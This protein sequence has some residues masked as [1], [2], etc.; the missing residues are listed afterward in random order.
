MAKRNYTSSSDART[1]AAPMTAT[2]ASG[3]PNPY[4]TITLNTVTT[5]SLPSDYP[6]TLVVEP[7]ISG[8]EEIITV[9]SQ[10]ST[11]VY[12]VNR[13]SDGTSAKAH[14][15]G[16]VVKHMVTARDL[17]EPQNHAEATG[18]YS[19][20]NDG[21][22]VGV[23]TTYI[24]KSLHGIGASEGNVVGTDKAQTLTNKTLTNP[25]INSASLFGTIT[26]TGTLAFGTNASV[27][28]A[29]STTI[30]ATEIAYLD[31]VTSAI[32]TQ[33][34][35]KAPT[36]SPTF[37]G[38]VTL[39]S[40][41]SLTS[42]TT[43][44][45]TLGGTTTL[46]S[47]GTIALGT[48]ASA[49][50]AN[51]VTISAAEFGYLDGLTSN[52]QTQITSKLTNPGAWTSWTPTLSWTFAGVTNSSKYI[53]IG[54][55]VYFNFNISASST[56]TPSGQFT[57]TLPVQPIQN[58]ASLTGFFQVASTNYSITGNYSSSTNMAFLTVP[59]ATA[60]TANTPLSVLSLTSS[61]V[62]LGTVTTTA[63][64]SVSVSGFY[65][66]A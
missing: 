41:T 5:S 13:A 14:A 65:E 63:N 49:L 36:A 66:V 4:S 3:S 45:A 38:T 20:K 52:I 2:T 6:Y 27:I 19:I 56:I 31:G 26:T 33:I 55:T 10:V 42:P 22:D 46:D 40:S 30:S 24:T 35:S 8:Q 23:T 16:S 11:Y 64:R 62:T 54:K 34:D 29:N 53:Q 32:Q 59:T 51:G 18:A 12:N 15:S 50:T 9:L 39:P 17:Q 47:S 21:S 28:T 58:G 44:N 48:N 60:T 61:I 7:D 57:F 37:T 1:L 25:Q 43:Y